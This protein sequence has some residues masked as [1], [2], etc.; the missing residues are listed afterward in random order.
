MVSK[1]TNSIYRGQADSGKKKKKR[2]KKKWGSLV[3]KQWG[4]EIFINYTPNLSNPFCFSTLLGTLQK[5]A[6]YQSIRQN[7]T[8]FRYSLSERS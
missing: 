5:L 1:V 3:L 2:K 8:Y 7:L 4:I 6:I